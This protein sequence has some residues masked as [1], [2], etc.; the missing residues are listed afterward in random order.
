[1]MRL[2]AHWQPSCRV[3]LVV[4]LSLSLFLA[5][6]AHAQ[7]KTQGSPLSATP[8]EVPPGSVNF[9]YW[10]VVL[11]NGNFVVVDPSYNDQGGAEKVGAVHL[12]DGAS[13]TLL[14]TLKGSVANSQV[15]SAGVVVVGTSNFV[16]RS[17]LWDANDATAD[18]GAATWVNGE[19]GLNGV[20]SASNSLVGSTA[21][22]RISV[23]GVVALENGNYVVSSREWDNG[24]VVDA[25]AVTWGNGATGTAGVVSPSNSLVGSQTNDRVGASGIVPLD[26]GNYVVSSG[27]WDNGALTNAGAVT[28]GNGASGTVGV[29]SP[30][31]SLVGSHANDEVG[32]E[33]VEALTNG[34][35]VVYVPAWDNGAIVNAGAVAWGNGTG[36]TVGAVSAANSL[37]GSQADDEVGNGSNRVLTNGNYLVSSPEWDNGAIVDAGAATWGNGASGTVGAVS[38]ANS[39]VGSQPDDT[40]SDGN[41]AVLTNGNYVVTSPGW[42]NGAISNAGAATWGNGEG[43]TVG[44]VSAANSLVG[45]QPDD[46]VGLGQLAVLTNGNYVVSSSAW[47]NGSVVNAGAATWGNGEGG[48]VGA[49]SPANSLVGSQTEDRVSHFVPIAL[50]NGNYVVRN[51]HWDNGSVVDAGAAT[52]G[53]GEGGT[54]GVITPANS[55]V[56]SQPEDEV[57]TVTA[58]TNGNYV[59]LSTYWNNG[60]VTTA[61][62]V[63]WGNGEGGTVGTVT[64]ANSLT[65]SQQGDRVGDGG[66]LALPN[67]NYVV[68]SSLWSQGAVKFVGA[69]TWG[70]GTGGTAGAVGPANSLVGNKLSDRVGELTLFSLPGSDYIVLS[71]WVDDGAEVDAG[72]LSWG[73]GETGL[74]GQ[75]SSENSLMNVAPSG[76]TV[77]VGRY[78]DVHGYLLVYRTNGNLVTVITNAEAPV[79]GNSTWLPNIQR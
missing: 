38:P 50:T 57:G 12:F 77:L 33:G 37:V 42:D 9:G 55:L 10:V 70:N 66:V 40:V 8:L 25:G 54:V 49:V 61:G 2:L 20:V 3:A 73:D 44:A 36:G 16:V 4:T 24:A 63:T 28:W 47:D 19:T 48:T 6:T 13:K 67:G 21:G 31:N 30:A 79:D 58:L 51:F 41:T 72:A 59:V 62:A 11:P 15:G 29:V 74:S 68:R 26:N 43:G 22:D 39:L 7:I 14:T 53:N 56:G 17:P 65:G 71:D 34:N 32:D 46:T 18:A 35:Y 76:T 27:E 60:A 5:N 64:T 45:S 78:N 23:S 1:M 52:W 75:V 69:I